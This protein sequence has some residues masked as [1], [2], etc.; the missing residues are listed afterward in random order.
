MKEIWITSR[1]KVHAVVKEKKATHVL[2]LIG[3]GKQ[4]YL[5]RDFKIENWLRMNF[6]DHLDKYTPGGPTRWHV[7]KALSWAKDLPEDAILLV[8]CEAGIS[9]SS[10]MA[11]SILVQ[12]KGN[13][14]LEA[15]WK[16]IQEIR[17][18]AC[19]NPVICEYADDE[20]GLGGAL[21][22]IGKDAWAERE[23]W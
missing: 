20:L 10:S 13:D 7:T 9:R 22:K 14:Q 17:P 18:Q 4:V 8:H 6:D 21:A 15:C 16:H 3:Y 5:P 23:L 2:S 11:L 19:P 12:Q 1:D